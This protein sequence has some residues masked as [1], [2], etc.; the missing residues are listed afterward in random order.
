MVL[1]MRLSLPLATALLLLVTASPLACED[2]NELTPDVAADIL[3]DADIPKD[4]SG[5]ADCSMDNQLE[6]FAAAGATACG[7][8][9]ITPGGGEGLAAVEAC[10]DDALSTGADFVVRQLQQGTDSQVETAWLRA[11]G[12]VLVLL[13]DSA[14]C[15]PRVEM[16]VCNSPV[17]ADFDSTEPLIKC[18]EPLAIEE[19]CGSS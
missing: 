1:V 16:A 17:R 9:P 2:S 12:Q 4:V 18:A 19:A 11:N 7:T 14:P 8:I 15:G 5:C 10:V 3:G 6:R 13:Y